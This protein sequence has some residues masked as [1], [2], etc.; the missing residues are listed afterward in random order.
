MS[1]SVRV[2]AA[3]QRESRLHATAQHSSWTCVFSCLTPNGRWII[4]LLTQASERHPKSSW[5]IGALGQQLAALV[6]EPSFLHYTKQGHREYSSPESLEGLMPRELA[7][8]VPGRRCVIGDKWNVW[9]VYECLVPALSVS[10]PMAG[11]TKFLCQVSCFSWVRNYH[12]N[13]WS[14]PQIFRDRY[15][16]DWFSPS[17]QAFSSLLKFECMN[18]GTHICL[19]FS[20]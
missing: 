10:A 5:E 14:M 13:H 1:H 16:I 3:K 15:W 8:E 2:S 20:W 17:A 7:W 11:P 18:L 12:L 6:R 4:C 19:P 9:V